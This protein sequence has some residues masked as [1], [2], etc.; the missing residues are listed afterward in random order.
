MKWFFASLSKS[1]FYN[2][3]RFSFK[4]NI[5]KCYLASPP[6][7]SEIVEKIIDTLREREKGKPYM[8]QYNRNT[9]YPQE[10]LTGPSL[11]PSF[12]STSHLP[13]MVNFG[14]IYVK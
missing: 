11:P 12:C 2:F 10:G 3:L 8:A 4:V 9:I 1:F 5:E 7:P 6:R 14:L 13:Y